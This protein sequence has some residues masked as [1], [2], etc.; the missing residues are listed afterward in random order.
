MTLNPIAERALPTP[1]SPSLMTLTTSRVCIDLSRHFLVAITL[2]GAHIEHPEVLKLNDEVEVIG[3]V[4]IPFRHHY[5][6]SGIQLAICM[7]NLFGNQLFGEIV[8]VQTS[9]ALSTIGSILTGSQL[10]T[11]LHEA[12]SNQEDEADNADNDMELRV[13][14]SAPPG[15]DSE[16]DSPQLSRMHSSSSKDLGS[17]DPA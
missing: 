13:M 5:H 7:V 14:F 9:L 12:Q 11:N 15:D 2:S 10:L 3:P 17:D 16:T 8:P 1:S 6:Y 4:N